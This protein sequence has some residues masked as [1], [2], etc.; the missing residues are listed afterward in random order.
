MFLLI[1]DIKTLNKCTCKSMARKCSKTGFINSLFRDS[2]CRGLCWTDLWYCRG[3]KA[4]NFYSARYLHVQR[5][6]V[7]VTVRWTLWLT[8][9]DL[10]CWR[11]LAC[12]AA[13]WVWRTGK[14]QIHV[15]SVTLFRWGIF[16]PAN[17]EQTPRLPAPVPGEPAYCQGFLS[18]LQNKANKLLLFKNL[19]PFIWDPFVGTTISVRISY[20]LHSLLL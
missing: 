10:C 3:T 19:V 17:I 8:L 7:T 2:L 14:K 9:Y 12:S 4:R 16:L 18:L 13:N 20:P 15:H 11:E 5:S 6:S 1:A